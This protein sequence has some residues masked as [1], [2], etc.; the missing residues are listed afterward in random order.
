MI[1]SFRRGKRSSSSSDSGKSHVISRITSGPQVRNGDGNASTV[2]HTPKLVI[3]AL[4]DYLPQGPDELA[5]KKGDFYHVLNDNDENEENGWYE[6][7]NP[8]SNAKGMVPI[9][10]FEV[11]NRSRPNPDMD[12]SPSSSRILSQ[13]SKAPSSQRNS[14]QTLYAIVL[15]GFKA[16][17]EDELDI[18][19][20]ENLIICAHHNYEWFIA[21]PINRL[22]GPGLVPVSYVKI[23]DLVNPNNV[24][25]N[26]DLPKVIDSFKIPSVEQWKDQT[27]KYQASTIPLGSISNQTPPSSSNTQYF[28]KDG[29]TP[30]SNRSSLSSS[31][32]VILEA[33]VD[34]YQLDHGRY[35]YL[36]VAKLGNSKVRYLYRYYQ[37]FYDL[38]VKLLELFPYEA[39]KI[40]NSKRIIPSIPGPLIN[41]NDSISK[42]RREKLD[43]YLRNL[44]ALPA[45]ISRSE[46][47]LRLFDVLN[48]GF[49][50][51]VVDPFVKQ[52]QSKPISQKSNYQQDR[53]SQYSIMHNHQGTRVSTTPT[54]SESN[55]NRSSQSSV[56]LFNNLQDPHPSQPKALTNSS[57]PQLV[58]KAPPTASAPVPVSGSKMKVKFYY[59]DDIFVLLLPSGLRLIDLKSKL[60]KRLNL[61]EE[62]KNECDPE[63]IRLY[64][65]ND[66]DGF[67]EENNLTDYTFND[68]QQLKLKEFEINND[69]KFHEV[70]YDKCKLCI[71]A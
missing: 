54:S 38:Q 22:G 48:N 67:Q 53:L 30:V 46:E 27:A 36:I 17:R 35:Q 39:G 57:Q 12:V 21:K 29:V 24:N 2:L 60:F 8:M 63:S 10:Y 42:L 5:F 18:I 43:Y 13:A 1:K 3:K 37:D 71:L 28:Q 70:L 32:T 47:V 20:G 58:T 19:P 26:D 40:E 4:Y 49:D 65:K 55:F 52:R 50:K 6:A 69:D 56:N 68:I 9:S 61:N 7:I 31:N 62:P 15:F 64:L 66:L 33:S 25:A 44:I 34:S 41:V 45:H 51:E 16:E 14:N 11:F 59:Q 23:V